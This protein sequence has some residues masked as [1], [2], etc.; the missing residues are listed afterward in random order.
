VQ[1]KNVAVNDTFEILGPNN[2]PALIDVRVE[3]DA[4]GQAMP[5]GKGTAVG[6]TDKGAFL[7]NIAPAKSTISF[8]GRELG[9]AFEGSGKAPANG[10]TWAQIGTERNG[11]FLR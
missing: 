5:R 9:L 4:I 2:T 3:W 6:A 7:G 11:S 1:A 10:K 8:S